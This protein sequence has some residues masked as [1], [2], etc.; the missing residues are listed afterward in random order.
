M[1]RVVA[2]VFAAGLLSIAPTAAA[3]VP[4][5]DC[6]HT[7]TG[8]TPLTDLGTGTYQGFQGGLYPGGTNMR[9]ASH[10]LA[11][12]LLAQQ[13]EPLDALGNPD[14]NGKIVVV[15]MG[16]SNAKQFFHGVQVGVF[17]VDPLKSANVVFING[18]YKAKGTEET[19]NPVNSFWFMLLADLQAAGSSFEQVQVL[20]LHTITREPTEPF[21][22]HAV[23]HQAALEATIHNAKMYMPNATIMYITSR[24]YA[25]YW[26]DIPV[27]AEPYSFEQGLATKWLIEDQINGA[28]SLNYDPANGPV[29]A[30]WIAWG[31][32]LWAD[33]VI[34]RS[35]GL[36][37]E[38]SDFGTDGL[39]PAS[40]AQFEVIDY[41]SRF[42][43]TDATARQWY[44][45]DDV[46]DLCAGQALVVSEG[47][48]LAGPTHAPRLAISDLPTVPSEVSL[49]AFAFDAP[50][51]ALGVFRV[52]APG[53]GALVPSR[54]AGPV[55]TTPSKL[56]F[57]PAD[58]LGQTVLELGP[59]PASPATW[60]GLELSVQ[61]FVQDGAGWAR[62][63]RMRLTTGH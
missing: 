35:D 29:L 56:F 57:A 32:Y 49:R 58:E 47:D 5:K 7:S 11:G 14:P 24:V 8:I 26:I 44:L 33:G 16:P 6:S 37:W 34:P 17:G 39:H 20:W 46:S 15:G 38:C 62:T 36:T 42:F 50:P 31:P 18:G 19:A 30:P 21:P 28:A 3:Q 41:M 43:H 10:D 22:Q 55:A 4:L 63:E 27:L 61:Y 45:G 59:V 9:P 48:A 23:S 60:C 53:I 13:I 51:G 2:V 1:S 25:D 12:V 52:S 40:P 54:A